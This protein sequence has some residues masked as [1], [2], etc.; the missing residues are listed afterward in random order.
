MSHSTVRWG[1]FEQW[2]YFEHPL[3]TLLYYPLT[4]KRNPYFMFPFLA[5]TQ[6]CLLL[7]F[8]IF[9]QCRQHQ[10]NFRGQKWGKMSKKIV[11]KWTLLGPK[12]A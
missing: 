4:A 8:S 1:D 12:M 10:S 9:S 2:G 3:G 11:K 5:Y 7:L 6:G